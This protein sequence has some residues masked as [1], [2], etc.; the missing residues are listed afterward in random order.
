M[1]DLEHQTGERD[2][3]A[4]DVVDP[5]WGERHRAERYGL[6]DRHDLDAQ[7]L[8]ALEDRERDLGVVHAPVEHL[9]AEPAVGIQLDAD[10]LQRLDLALEL[11]ERRLALHRV[12]AA[13]RDEAI[14]P[15]FLGLE[16]LLERTAAVLEREQRERVMH[17]DVHV[18]LEEEH[19]RQFLDRPVAEIRLLVR[20]RPVRGVREHRAVDRDGA[21]G[22]VV[23]R[24]VLGLEVV[25]VNNR[26]DDRDAVDHFSAPPPGTIAA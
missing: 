16:R 11:L 5:V 3:R 18:A 23:V 10:R 1:H 14:R 4:V 6:V 12:D 13:V 19:V 7:L 22:A 8:G 2:G 20:H 21:L 25:R 15:P 26:V 24:V 17:G 9:V